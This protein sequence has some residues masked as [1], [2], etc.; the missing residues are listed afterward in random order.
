MFDGYQNLTQDCLENTFHEK[1]LF[2]VLP[3][4]QHQAHKFIEYFNAIHYI[5]KYVV[6]N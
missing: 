6:V 1:P 2:E 3:N 5:S 4:H